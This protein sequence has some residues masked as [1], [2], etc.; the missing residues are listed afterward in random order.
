M[1]MLG[2]M[3]VSDVYIAEPPTVYGE[4]TITQLDDKHNDRYNPKYVAMMKDGRSYLGL[5][6]PSQV[7]KIR[8]EGWHCVILN[9]ISIQHIKAI[10]MDE[11]P[12]EVVEYMALHDLDPAAVVSE[13]EQQVHGAS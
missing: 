7:R 12:Y 1:T 8:R 13:D 9:D 4:M 5:V 10:E 2:H 3:S 6:T 11:P